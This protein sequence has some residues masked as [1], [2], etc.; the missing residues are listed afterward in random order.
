MEI[1]AEQ[2]YLVLVYT[3]LEEAN[4]TRVLIT[5][6]NRNIQMEHIAFL[7]VLGYLLHAVAPCTY[8]TSEFKREGDYLIGGLFD[9]HYVSSPIFHKR[10]ETL[11]CSR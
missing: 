1:S 2:T 4:A 11:D 5:L 10:P 9:I 7:C 3:P 8:A 6:V